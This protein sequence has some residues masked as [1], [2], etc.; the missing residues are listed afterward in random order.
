MR[1]YVRRQLHLFECALARSNMSPEDVFHCAEKVFMKADPA[2]ACHIADV[3]GGRL[4]VYAAM[5]NRV[6]L[7]RR[8][9][10][11][12][13]LGS[14]VF[15][16]DVQRRRGRTPATEAAEFGSVEVLEMILQH[17]FPSHCARWETEERNSPVMMARFADAVQ[18]LVENGAKLNSRND[19]GQGPLGMAMLGGNDESLALMLRSGAKA[20]QH[21]SGKGKSLLEIAV[22]KKLPRALGLLL[23]NNVYGARNREAL[24]RALALAMEGDGRTSSCILPS[25]LLMQGADLLFPL[26]PS[27]DDVF[28]CLSPAAKAIRTGSRR[29][30]RYIIEEVSSDEDLM[31]ARDSNGRT[32][33]YHASQYGDYRL[34]RDLIRAGASLDVEDKYYRTALVHACDC[35]RGRVLNMLLRAGAS[36]SSYK[37]MCSALFFAA[38]SQNREFIEALL[39][40]NAANKTED[41]K[42]FIVFL[43]SGL[44]GAVYA[45]DEDI[46][47]LLLDCGARIDAQNGMGICPLPACLAFVSLKLEVC[48]TQAFQNFMKVWGDRHVGSSGVS[49]LHVV[50]KEGRRFQVEFLLEFGKSDV[51]AK[52]QYGLTPLHYAAFHGNTETLAALID[53]GCDCSIRV[54]HSFL[55]PR[56]LAGL[57]AFLLAAAAGQ[58]EC[59]RILV[60]RGGADPDS[61]CE[62]NLNCYSL[63]LDPELSSLSMKEQLRVTKKLLELGAPADV[64]NDRGFRPIHIAAFVGNFEV[65]YLLVSTHGVDINCRTFTG[66]YVLYF[67]LSQVRNERFYCSLCLLTTSCL[68][69]FGGRATQHTA[70]WP[71]ESLPKCQLGCTS[72]RYRAWCRHWSPF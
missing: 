20:H 8:L 39:E 63:I 56:A 9:V 24:S 31:N 66:E 53:A 36:S 13:E 2:S 55:L 1:S 7:A 26:H 29:L 67:S 16:D 45:G 27:E 15:V 46:F 61:R 19:V 11:E 17:W 64:K 69:F 37:G 57:D 12:C 71:C 14:E 70:L 18:L 42:E 38:W 35:E 10:V 30:A 62:H 50:A 28:G 54:D 21:Y 33:L 68:V 72:T 43:S 65:L 41:P 22:E 34:A 4:L 5:L 60:Q 58:D 47:R 3:Y 23:R 32:L 51:D 25:M 6:D 52:D 48:W 59:A 49:C 44:T 40:A